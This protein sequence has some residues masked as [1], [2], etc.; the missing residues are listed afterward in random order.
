MR[1]RGRD[2]RR[3]TYDLVLSFGDIELYTFTSN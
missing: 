1:A 2:G 3:V